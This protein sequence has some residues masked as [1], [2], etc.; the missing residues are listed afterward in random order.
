MALIHF[1]LQG[2]DLQSPLRY[3]KDRIAPIIAT[4]P[5]PPPGLHGL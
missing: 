3:V 4:R 5:R 2:C 1:A